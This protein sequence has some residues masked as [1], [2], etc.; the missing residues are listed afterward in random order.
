MISI[1]WYR[2]SDEY[3]NYLNLVKEIENKL[4]LQ[5]KKNKQLAL[6]DYQRYLEN[7]KQFQE[8]I[9]YFESFQQEMNQYFQNL[10]NT[11]SM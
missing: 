8:H 6:K 9:H 11:I 2:Y 1:F 3:V 5:I 7:E 4:I 10:Q